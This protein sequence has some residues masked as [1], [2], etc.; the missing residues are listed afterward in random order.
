[1]KQV[2]ESDCVKLVGVPMAK[3]RSLAYNQVD[4]TYLIM[5]LIFIETE[6]DCS[7]TLPNLLPDGSLRASQFESLDK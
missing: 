2:E 1:M 7:V 3:R 4:L 5:A 6:K